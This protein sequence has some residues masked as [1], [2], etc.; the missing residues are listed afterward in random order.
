MQFVFVLISI[1]ACLANKYQPGFQR[2][3]VNIATVLDGY[4]T[5][6]IG[7]LSYQEAQKQFMIWHE[8]S[9]KKNLI[10][11]IGESIP[12]AHIGL[13]G[14]VLGL[15]LDKYAPDLVVLEENGIRSVIFAVRPDIIKGTTIKISFLDQEYD[16]EQEKL[17]ESLEQSMTEY[18]GISIE[19]FEIIALKHESKYIQYILRS[20][21]DL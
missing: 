11:L 15:Q 20:H 5:E 6:F 9:T 12:F 4:S 21:E 8:K 13:N 3:Q 7:L 16:N 18:E 1:F 2:V 10:Y 17:I 14:S 19:K